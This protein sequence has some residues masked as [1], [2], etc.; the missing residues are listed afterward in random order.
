MTPTYRVVSEKGPDH[1]KWF[2]VVAVI[3]DRTYLSGGGRSKKEA[4]QT[5]ARESLAKLLE[6]LGAGEEA[7]ESLS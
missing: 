5:A 3:G 4:E 2:Q 6:E 1:H 7:I